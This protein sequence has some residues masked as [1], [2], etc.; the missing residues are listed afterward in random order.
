MADIKFSEFTESDAIQSIQFVGFDGLQNTKTTHNGLIK[1]ITLSTAISYVILDND[2]YDRIE[3]D[4]T[5]GDITITLPTRA[6][7]LGR[8]IEIANIKGTNKVIIAADAG[9]AKITNNGLTA[10]WLPKIGNYIVL[11][12]CATST[13]WDVIDEKI[14]SQLRLNTYAGYGSTDTKIMRFT[15]VVENVGNMFSEN[16]VSGY[17]SNQKGLEITINRSGRYAFHFS[18]SFTNDYAGLSLNSNQLTTAIYN[19][20]QSAILNMSFAAT[21]AGNS[22]NNVTCTMYFNKGDIIR[23]H[24]GGAGATAN[25]FFTVTYLG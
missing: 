9:E 14:T 16:H 17:T 1:K 10:V 15:N 13:Y 5:S 21:A 3:V 7:N 8:R 25:S 23:P 6:D 22:D 24:T 12:E 18:P 2:Q 11:Q 19:I 20:T 4:T